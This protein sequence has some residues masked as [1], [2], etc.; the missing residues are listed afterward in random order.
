MLVKLD[1]K[2]RQH[3]YFSH[4]LLRERYANASVINIA[5]SSLPSLP[6]IDDHLRWLG[7]NCDYDY[8]I[9]TDP[10]DGIPKAIAT[11]RVRYNS[12]QDVTLINEV[13]I[14]VLE[15]YQ[16]AGAGTSALTELFEAVQDKLYAKINPANE[17]SE[18]LFRK[19]G[20]NHIANIWSRDESNKSV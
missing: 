18:G 5:G 8:Y 13:G 11:I 16:G 10:A 17:R 2:N 9:W 14:F 7:N 4:L 15:E 6:P 12:Q 1:A 19:L 20:L 3:G